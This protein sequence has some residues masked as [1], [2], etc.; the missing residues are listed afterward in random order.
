MSKLKVWKENAFDYVVSLINIWSR[1]GECNKCFQTFNFILPQFCSSLSSK[2]VSYYCIS[3]ECLNRWLVAVCL[4]ESVTA[5]LMYRKMVILRLK[6]KFLNHSCA[7]DVHN[8]ASTA[9]N[10]YSKYSS[11]QKYLF[12]KGTKFIFKNCKLKVKLNL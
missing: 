10:S 11:F 8:G 7:L 12:S 2:D 5:F 6:T 4:A 3:F 9:C 1:R